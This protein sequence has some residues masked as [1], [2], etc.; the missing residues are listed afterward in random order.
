MGGSGHCALQT[1]HRHDIKHAKRTLDGMD[2]QVDFAAAVA[3]TKT[4]GIA[5]TKVQENMRQ[6]FDR[7]TPWVINSLRLKSA[8]KTNLV[9]EVAFKD[10]NSEVSSKTMVFPHVEGGQRSFKAMEVRLMQAGLMPSGYNAVPGEAAKMD[11]FGNMNRG[12]IT[13]LLNILGTYREAGYNKADARTVARLAKG[14][15]SAYGFEYF[16]AKVGDTRTKH[17]QPG[18]YQRVKTPFGSSLKPVLMFVR[19]ANYKKRLDFYG[20]VNDVAAQELKPQF[21]QALEMAMATAR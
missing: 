16:V 11:A 1:G 14:R 18:V 2:K 10:I 19:R 7:P 3:L 8:T 5:R 17:L 9:A 6:V 13:T 21:D 20:I 15:G 12:Q 4:A